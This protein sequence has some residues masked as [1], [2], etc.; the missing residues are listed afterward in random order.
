M[1]VSTKIEASI[2][3]DY[4]EGYAQKDVDELNEWM[5]QQGINAKLRVEFGDDSERIFVSKRD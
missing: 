4:K 2:W 5:Y 1:G 3:R